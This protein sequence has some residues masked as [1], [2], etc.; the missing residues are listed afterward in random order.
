L[1]ADLHRQRD[2]ARGRVQRIDCDDVD[3]LMRSEIVQLDGQR[4]IVTRIEV[5]RDDRRMRQ[6]IETCEPA[7]ISGTGS[8]R[9]RQLLFCIGRGRGRSK[10][11]AFLRVLFAG[12]RRTQDKRIEQHARSFVHI[13]G[14]PFAVATF[15]NV[16]VLVADISAFDVGRQRAT[17]SLLGEWLGIVNNQIAE[18]IEFGNESRGKHMHASKLCRV[19]EFDLQ[20]R[21]IGRYRFDLQRFVTSLFQL[22]ISTQHESIGLFSV[23]DA[24]QNASSMRVNIEMVVARIQA[25]DADKSVSDSQRFEV[26]G[27]IVAVANFRS[28][29]RVV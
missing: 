28:R 14:E 4:A 3:V 17:G 24:N 10:L 19:P 9:L 5:D 8:L 20:R 16:A 27:D 11:T 25:A 29:S 13:A 22:T 1:H 2:G 21:V 7:G 12:F 6:K 15:Q 18:R 26:I 23:S